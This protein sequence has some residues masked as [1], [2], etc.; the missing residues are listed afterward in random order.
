MERARHSQELQEKMGAEQVH[1][2]EL[3]GG[4]LRG[5]A[6]GVCS[7]IFHEGHEGAAGY[8]VGLLSCDLA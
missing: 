2:A 3:R 6:A 8:V 5:D 4:P 1:V 7:K